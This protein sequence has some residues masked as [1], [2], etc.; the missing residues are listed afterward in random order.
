MYIN[1]RFHANQNTTHVVQYK[2]S[3][4]TN[5]P[6]DIRGRLH[7]IALVGI[8]WRDLMLSSDGADALLAACPDL[9]R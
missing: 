7:A 6:G 2:Y 5:L 8:A 4:N 9:A 1:G 3:A